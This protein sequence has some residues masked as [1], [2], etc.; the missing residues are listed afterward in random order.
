MIG[1]DDCIKR[2]FW[3]S[4]FVIACSPVKELNEHH[5]QRRGPQRDLC[6]RRP[7]N[8]GVICIS[9]A[10]AHHFGQGELAIIMAY[11]K[12]PV[13]G[14]GSRFFKI[15]CSKSQNGSQAANSRSL[16]KVF[17]SGT[18]AAI[19]AVAVAMPLGWLSLLVVRQQR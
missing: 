14:T 9:G 10:A 7:E 11:E 12:V 17:A 8:S 6:H 1:A 13:V 2:R 16:P 4:G 19:F 3:F 18:V 15:I 5:S